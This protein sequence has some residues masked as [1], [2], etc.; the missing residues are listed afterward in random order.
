[1]SKNAL[2]V[3]IASQDGSYLAE[4][5]LEKGYQVIGTV[6]QKGDDIENIHSSKDKL[7][8]ETAD[9]L[10]SQSLTA[11]VKKHTPSEIYNLAA[12]SLPSA[13]WDK[14]YL[15]TQVTGLGPLLLLESVRNFSPHSHIFQASTREIFGE[16]VTGLADENT[17]INPGSPYGAA[18]AYAHFM[19]DIYRRSHN[20]FAVN[21]IL[22]NHESPR[23]PL[24]FVTRKI[25]AAAACIKNNISSI[26]SDP[27]GQP[28]LDA[29]RKLHLWEVD[30]ARDRGY[31]KDYVEAMWRLLQSSKPQD[32][33][34]ASGVGFTVADICNTGFSY[35]GLNWQDHVIIDSP[36]TP[37]I[38]RTSLVGDA[39][40]IKSDL[41]WQPQV[42]FPDVVKLMVDSDLKLF[43]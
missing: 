11:V 5:L 27:S 1:M 43:K 28:I 15:T 42:P 12:L 21:G 41:G 25:T 31:A 17:P 35:V 38:P 14:A 37:S 22:F 33:V 39:S 4:L 16:S 26:P 30:S 36:N 8:L 3:G 24:H 13:S 2:I 9:L 20:I 19:V 6:R 18:K 29:H 10:D 34:I 23:R 7:V 40:K 32:Y